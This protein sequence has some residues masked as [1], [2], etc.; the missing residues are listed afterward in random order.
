MTELRGAQRAG[1]ILFLGVAMRE[2]PD[3]ISISKVYRSMRRCLCSFPEAAGTN[4][5][6]QCPKK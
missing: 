5:H 2:F 1:E 3:K 6:K 4:D